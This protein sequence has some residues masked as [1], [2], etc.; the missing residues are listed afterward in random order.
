MKKIVSRSVFKGL[1]HYIKGR[2]RRRL[3][4][5]QPCCSAMKV[6]GAALF[7][8]EA[9]PN[10]KHGDSLEAKWATLVERDC[11]VCWRPHTHTPACT[12]SCKFKKHKTHT[13]THT[14][15]TTTHG[16][17][18]YLTRAHTQT[19]VL[20]TVNNPTVTLTVCSFQAS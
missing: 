20:I 13:H 10:R 12:N 14:S 3:G 6:T 17:Q 11:C 2:K 5:C 18:G 16:S 7:L 15:N 9:S 4:M 19:D 8:L 1:F